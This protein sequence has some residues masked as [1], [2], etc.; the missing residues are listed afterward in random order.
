[1]AKGDG[2]IT[3]IKKPDGT[4]YKP[5]HW[6]VRIDCGTDSITKKR[7]VITRTVRGTKADA[8]KERD[9]IKAELECGI[10]AYSRDITF[11]AFAM[12]WQE[13][14]EAAGEV[15]LARLRRER[16]LAEALVKY[17][18]Q[19]RLYEITPQMVEAL[20]TKIRQDRTEVRGKCS[21]TT[22]N[23][24]HKLFKMIMA[25]AVD[26]NLILRNPLDKVKAPR[27]ETPDRR[28]LTTEEARSLLAKI[29]EAENDA[30]E[31][32]IGIERRQ[33]ARG[34]I[35]E[36]SYLRGL[37][38]IGNVIGARIGLATGMRRGEVAALIWEH[39]DLKAGTIRVVQSLTMFDEVKEPKSEAG[40]RTLNI[41][42][43]TVAHLEKWKEFQAKEMELLGLQQTDKTP[44][45]CSDKATYIKLTNFS[46]WWRSFCEEN[47]FEGLK[48]HE[49][50]HTQ[51]T[52][53]IANGVDLKTVQNRLGHASPT[54]TMN[55][56]AHALPE[57][58]QQAA[59]LIGNLFSQ[60]AKST[61]KGGD[62]EQEALKEAS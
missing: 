60:P 26:Y 34:D 38:T 15:S 12:Q 10:E 7:R 40:K 3:E 16:S 22:M 39:V 57:R 27:C 54:L 8:C 25:K 2:S 1:M 53:L 24:Y 42:S 4:C 41:D 52:Q 44:V 62:S 30:Y 13:A 19:V 51:A 43:N 50:R 49:L 61:D 58:D 28:S 23:M 17:L 18:D 5:K 9:R 59:E 32:R 56:Y 46:R 55:F 20:Y 6:K 33:D 11:G 14:R 35:S 48:F 21:G 37:S 45:C 47:G 36:R 31:N 29:D